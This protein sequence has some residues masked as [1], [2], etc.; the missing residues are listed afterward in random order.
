MP[1]PLSITEGAHQ[2]S[3]KVWDGLNNKTDTLIYLDILPLIEEDNFH[4]SRVYPIP[5][6]FSTNTHFTMISTHFPVDIFINI[7]SINGIKVRTLNSQTIDETS[8]GF[9][10]IG[11]NGKDKYGYEIAN[12]AY[13]YHIKAETNNNLHFA[14]IYKL[15][16][17]E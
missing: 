17:I 5:N 1:V 4:L 14:G 10:S 16:K 2:L 3:L 11:W 8:G 13:Y 6:P 15:A 12:G 7:Y 9:V